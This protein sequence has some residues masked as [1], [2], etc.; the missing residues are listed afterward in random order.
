MEDDME[1]IIYAVY[2]GVCD[3]DLKQVA[4]T[5]KETGVIRT[6]KDVVD[7]FEYHEIIEISKEIMNLSGVNAEK[8]LKVK[9]VEDLKN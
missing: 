8:G 6:Y 4:T 2:I 5:L 9:V 3:P 7:M 1:G